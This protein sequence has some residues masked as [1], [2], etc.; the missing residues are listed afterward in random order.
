ML[1]PPFALTCEGLTD[2]LGIDVRRPR[3]SWHYEESF[4][5][6]Y[7]NQA[8][9]SF[10]YKY[11][12]G[13]RPLEPGFR[14]V[15]VRPHPGGGLTHTRIGSRGGLT[16]RDCTEGERYTVRRVLEGAST[17]PHEQP[18]SAHPT[19]LSGGQTWQGFSAMRT[20]TSHTLT[21]GP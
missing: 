3:L 2:P 16:A 1:R 6:A 13:I 12:A 11:V 17:G 7:Q 15:E 4:Q 8:V 14:R 9:G 10:L 20:P 18:E 19:P 21:T 5:T